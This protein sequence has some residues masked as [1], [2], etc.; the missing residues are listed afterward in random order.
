MHH[1]SSNDD[2]L[3]MVQKA[4]PQ[5]TELFEKKAHCVLRE[6]Q[7]DDLASL[8]SKY[9]IFPMKTLHKACYNGL[10]SLK[11]TCDKDK[12]DN[13]LSRLTTCRAKD[14]ELWQGDSPCHG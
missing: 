11:R 14:P 6:Q 13:L 1:E 3:G 4:L 8:R 12:T 5:E 7:F 10:R 2:V 9:T